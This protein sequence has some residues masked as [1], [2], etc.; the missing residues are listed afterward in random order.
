MILNDTLEEELRVLVCEQKKE[1][2]QLKQNIIVLKRMVAEESQ[3]K[4]T[5]WAL[6]ADR[7][8]NDKTNI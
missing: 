6:A 2:N 4:Y 8:N 3:A 5:A 1:I 7:T